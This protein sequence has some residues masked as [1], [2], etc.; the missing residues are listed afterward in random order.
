MKMTTKDQQA[1]SFGRIATCALIPLAAIACRDQSL[2][3]P[4]E[5]ET[6][7]S[8]LLVGEGP[9]LSLSSSGFHT[10]ARLAGGSVKCWGLN[11]RGQ[12]GNGTT[13]DPTPGSKSSMPSGV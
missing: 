2:P 3:P 11:E 13:V 12:L 5:I 4:G 7:A 10:C 6:R 9:V 8:N 1:R